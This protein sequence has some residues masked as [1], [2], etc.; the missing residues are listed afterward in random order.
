MLEMRRLLGI[1]REDED[2]EARHPQPRLHALPQLVEALA[3]AGLV[4]DEHVDGPPRTLPAAQDVSAY[5]IVQEA[6]T[7]A[8]RHGDGTSADVALRWQD[9]RLRIEV[10]NPVPPRRVNGAARGHGLVGIRER[11]AL[12]DGRFSAG[13]SDGRFVLVAELPYDGE[14]A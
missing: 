3:G 14:P 5:R 8:L 7:N 1:L 6:L 9:D 11:V 12:F 10:T 4:V 13:A 2:A